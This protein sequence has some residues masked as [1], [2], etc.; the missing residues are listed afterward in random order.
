MPRPQTRQPLRRHRRRFARADDRRAP[1][2]PQ[3]TEIEVTLAGSSARFL[4]ERSGYGI[5]DAELHEERGRT[6][7]IKGS[8]LA[9]CQPGEV[10]ACTGAWKKDPKWGWSFVVSEH[11]SALPASE[12][13][14]ARWLE[15]RVEGIGP[16]F[17]KAIVEHFGADRVF[18]EIDSN[19]E[20][21]REVRS[22][23]GR[24]IS[25]R[26]VERAIAAWERVRYVRELESFLFQHGVSVGLAD[27]LYRRYGDQ[28]IAILQ[29]D[30]YRIT[31]LPQVG[32]LIADKIARSLGVQLSDPRRLRSGLLFILREAEG[33]GHTYLTFEQLV[34]S[35]GKLIGVADVAALA[36]AARVLLAEKRIA[37][38]EDG[39]DKRLYLRRTYELECRV[40]ARVRDLI[41][42]PRGS[43]FAAPARPRAPE[44]ASASALAACKLPSDDQWAAIELVR[45]QR[46]CLLTGGPGT[47]KSLTVALLVELAKK[48][49][50]RVKLAAPTGKAARRLTELSG[51]PAQTL[52]RL[53]EYS[54]F[55]EGFQRG[56][57]NPIDADLIVVDEASMIDLEL[58]DAFLA[59]V[60]PATHVLFVGDPDQLPPVGIGRFLS[61]LIAARTRDGSR[62][63][64]PRV[65]LTRIFRQ[66]ARSMIVRNAARINEG[67]VPLLRYEDAV[68]RYGSDM[69]EDFFFIGASSYERAQAVLLE[70]VCKR[71]PRVYGYDPREQIMVLAPMRKGELGLDRLNRLLEER[72]NPGQQLPPRE[73][74][75]ARGI[76]IGSRVMQTKNDYSEGVEL[77]NGEVG[78]VTGFDEHARTLE[79]LVDD[80]QRRIELPLASAEHLVLAWACSVHKAQGSEFPC[81]VICSSTSHY[82][83]NTRSLLY[84]AVTRASELCVVIGHA[85]SDRRGASAAIQDAVANADAGKRNSLLAA[86]IAHPDLS[87]HLF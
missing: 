74:I 17:A 43:L 49:G 16:T 56:E 86:R 24:A 29:E 38:E 68:A 26:Q 80:G 32:F 35:A 23:S 44:G 84:T 30:A 25:A 34:R 61:D 67:K 60:G 37:V 53:L 27:K 81:V 4:D 70:M 3:A 66:A 63:A 21:L 51:E 33:E 75:P 18:A 57:G 78:I 7:T 42:N 47:G 13:G 79:L 9:H 22:A 55:E 19:P 15:A 83:L 14:I 46:L 28:V 54:P 85:E 71:I 69:V 36:Q 87:G 50:K 39:D 45:R 5:W 20:R 59:A 10:L 31:E 12:R 73:V 6:V 1:A 41:E 2:R 64:A 65:H 72:L 76:R 40:A 77:M 58:A 82:I 52:H 62:P 8:G 11:R 48:A